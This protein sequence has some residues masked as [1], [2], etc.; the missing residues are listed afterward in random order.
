[1]VALPQ[2]GLDGNDAKPSEFAPIEAGTYNVQI[3]NSKGGE[4]KEGRYRIGLQLQVVDGE[5]ENR[6]FWLNFNYINPNSQEN[7]EISQ[8][9]LRRIAKAC[10][11][12]M[13]GKTEDLHNIPFTITVKVNDKNPQYVSNE[14]TSCKPLGEPAP[15]KAAAAKAKTAAKPAAKEPAGKAAP[16]EKASAGAAKGDKPWK[17]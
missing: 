12:G 9:Q 2:G 17:K 1:M 15:S 16:K 10:N 8:E 14:M 7:Q 11:V 4:E 6:T 5:E 13:F 3:I